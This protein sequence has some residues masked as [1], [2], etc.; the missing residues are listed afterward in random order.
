MD[1]FAKYAE[2]RAR[3]ARLL[4]AGADPFG[5]RIDEIR[6]A[7]EAV[8]DGRPTILLGTNN[9]LGLTF[10]PA[11]REAAAKAALEQGTGTTGSRVANGTYGLHQQVEAGFRRFFDRRHAIVFTT[12]YQANLATISALAGPEDVILSDA[13]N[14]ASIWD[15]C[16]LAEAET[17]TFRHND[18]DHLDKRLTR[19]A[20]RPGCR[21]I[22]VEGLYSM[23]GD[24][25]PLADF[26]AVKERHPNAWLLVDEA[27]STGV[28]GAHGRGVGEAL[29]CEKGIDFIVGTFSKSLAGT[30]GFAVS[31]HPDFELLR[32]TAKPYMFAASP[33]PSSMASTGEALRQIE[34]RPA[35]RE[36]IWANAR[37]LHEGLARSGFTLCAGVGPVVAVRMPDVE[38]TVAAWN[39][40]IRAGVYV[41]F[42]IPPGTPGGLCLLRCSVSAAHTAGQIDQVIERFAEVASLPA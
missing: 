31:D 34:T 14:H 16:R 27:H 17:F 2:V 7:T 5:Q 37:R 28:Y 29:G 32:L 41:N 26:V 36:A 6:S 15:G 21:L 23:R 13:D 39:A 35:L 4:E 38:T 18:P 12:G 25:A 22:V 33:T 20:D 11:C 19:L 30:G 1:I 8:V 42:A 40:L 3:H 9:Y 24:T 10:D